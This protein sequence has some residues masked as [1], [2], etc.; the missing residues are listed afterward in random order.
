MFKAQLKSFGNRFQI[1]YCRLGQISVYEVS[2]G[3]NRHLRNF[4]LEETK[5]MINQMKSEQLNKKVEEYQK[6]IES[7]QQIQS[8]VKELKI[9]INKTIEKVQSNLNLI[10]NELMKSKPNIQVSSFEEDMKVLLKN[11]KDPYSFE[12]PQ[13]LLTSINYNIYIESI[14][15][16]LESLIKCPIFNQIF[17]AL[18]KIKVEED[19]L[20]VKPFKQI[21]IEESPYKTP[22]LNIQCN[23]HGKEIIMFNLNPEKTE[24][25]RLICVECIQSNNPIKYTTLIDTNIQWNEYLGQ[26]SVKVQQFEQQRN[27]NST[28]ILQILEELKEKH[29]STISDIIDQININYSKIEKNE[30]YQINNK[31]IYNMSIEQ[32]NELAEILSQKDKLKNLTEKQYSIQK[33]D[34]NKLEIISTSLGKLQRKRLKATNKINKIYKE[35]FINIIE[36]KDQKNEILQEEENEISNLQ[37]IKQLNLQLKNLK[38]FQDILQEAQSQYESVIKTINA[39]S[40]LF[41]NQQL[42]KFN[43]YV[44]QFEQDFSIIRK[45]KYFD[46]IEAELNLLRKDNQSLQNR[47]TESEKQNQQKIIEIDKQNIEQMLMIALLRDQKEVLGTKVKELEQQNRQIEVNLKEKQQQ[48]ERF[49]HSNQKNK[50]IVKQLQL[51]LL[52]LQFSQQLTFSTTYKHNNCQVTQNGKVIENDSG[53]WSCCM[54]D[55]MIPKNGIILSAFQI[56]E[57]TYIMIGI[58]FRDIVQSKGYSNC[59]SIGGGTYNIYNE[60]HCYNHDQQDKNDKQISFPFSTNDIII[61]E[62]D[63]QKKYIKW[64]KQ[65]TNQ[66]FTLTIDTSKDLYPCV[67]LHS[68][69][70]IKI[71]NQIFR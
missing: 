31:S 63:I 18:Q 51:T 25:S 65:S 60:G 17:E 50:K 62:V 69:C 49:Q 52:N 45:L 37:Q 35:Q 55:Q 40:I 16:Q 68:R 5:I 70:K 66:S 59:H 41:K 27:S 22:G 11:Y 34:F 23:K 19:Q 67:H 6:M 28:Q 38:I 39:L 57:N 46:N 71:L 43:E 4:L 54:C 44:F 48:L 12:V 53:Q 2:N 24:F 9:S 21:F 56:I 3:K 32:L 58:G 10:E 29:H 61:V 36:D 15:Q 64:T 26:K 20:E 30:F 14:Q 8:L 7:F 33:E 1:I 47:L 13:Q 42:Q